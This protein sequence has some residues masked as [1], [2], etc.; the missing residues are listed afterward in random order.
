MGRDGRPPNPAGAGRGELPPPP[1]KLAN[2]KGN[3]APAII[4][5]SWRGVRP[6]KAGIMMKY[7]GAETVWIS[8]F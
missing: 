1:G 6:A 8:N 3:Y 5:I 4:I 2:Q 7:D